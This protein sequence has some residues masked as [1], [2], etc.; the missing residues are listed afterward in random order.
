MEL[1]RGTVTLVF[2][3]I[4]GSTR[5]LQDLGTEP[6]VRAFEDH[7]RLLRKAFGSHGG[8]EVELQGDS[9]HFAFADAQEAVLAADQAR[10]SLAEHPWESE[11]VRVRIGIH[12]GEPLVSGH[13]YAG[14]DVHRAARVMSAGHG[15]QVLVSETTRELVDETFAMQ[16]LGEHRLKD[17]QAPLRLF[18]LG[19]EDFPPLK[20]LYQTNLPVPPTPFLGRERELDELSRLLMD[21]NVRLLTLTGPGGTGKTRLAVQAAAEAA[22]V[23]PDGIFWV[24]LAPLRDP[25]LV[26]PTI[27][28]VL[29]AKDDLVGHLESRKVLLLVDNLE[30]LLQAATE[31]GELLANCP[32]L[33]VLATSREPLH[34][35]AEHEYPIQPLQESDAVTLF[36]ERARAAGC[37]ITGNGEVPE[38]CRRLDHLPLAIELAAA[39]AKTLPPRALL[40]RLDQRLPL[41]T[42]GP[43]DLPERQQTLRSTIA[44][45]HELLGPN[46]QLLFARLAVFA[47]GCTL[48]SAEQI[49]AAEVDTLHSLV[50]KNL[51]R[52]SNERY[53]MLETIREFARE[54]LDS[55]GE[56]DEV[57]RT[58][59]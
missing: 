6:Y 4:E 37:A 52:R 22:E 31:L 35:S 18:Q 15:G 42:G 34:L 10:K 54:Q 45:S 36:H 7:R 12:T 24:A 26:M 39:R 13:V 28:Q 27:A 43:R 46:E 44:W 32:R 19:D 5:L 2:T 14:L 51:L 47:G 38:I 9:F 3:D 56:V 23:Y 41:L 33:T 50:D 49:C 21:G 30:H 53:W 8:I 55:S 20:S 57:R 1:P 40:E 16:D 29:G 48:E 59:R 58:P 17:L 11:P 25:T